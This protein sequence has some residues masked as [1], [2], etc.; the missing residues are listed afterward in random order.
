ME[1][2]AVRLKGRHVMSEFPD[3]AFEDIMLANFGS[4]L[5]CEPGESMFVNGDNIACVDGT[6]RVVVKDHGV[7]VARGQAIVLAFGQASVFAS[8]QVKVVACGPYVIV[9]TTGG[10]VQ[11]IRRRS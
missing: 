9:K 10:Q 11:M 4:A 6:T 8:D 2:Q 3:G 7:V 1:Y 5:Q